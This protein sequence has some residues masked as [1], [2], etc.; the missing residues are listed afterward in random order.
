M[1]AGHSVQTPCITR[2]DG[3]LPQLIT[4]PIGY[5]IPTSYE[6]PDDHNACGGVNS[7]VHGLKRLNASGIKNKARTKYKTVIAI[8]TV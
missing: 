7:D 3:R 6:T 5:T 1:D 4:T 2:F 8:G